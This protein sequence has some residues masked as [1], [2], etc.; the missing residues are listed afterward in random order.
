MDKSEEFREDI[1]HQLINPG[2]IEKAPEGFTEELLA[3]I[4]AENAPRVVI[5]RN[6]SNLKILLISGIVGAMLV[7][8]TALFPSTD[9]NSMISSVWNSLNNITLTFPDISFEKSPNFAFPELIIYLSI[10]IFMLYLFDL[11][12]NNL[13]HRERK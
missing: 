5:R 8:S 11:A 3:R 10:G 9:K 6:E 13:F 1:L 12:L 7:I 4:Q 2:K